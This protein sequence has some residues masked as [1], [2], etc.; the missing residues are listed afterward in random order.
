MST[1]EE[2]N[3][4]GRTPPELG[5]LSRAMPGLLAPC[6]YSEHAVFP[7]ATRLVTLRSRSRSRAVEQP[8]G[9]HRERD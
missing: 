9:G 8:Q 5:R 3:L 7:L 2:C 4:P 6:T 1:Q